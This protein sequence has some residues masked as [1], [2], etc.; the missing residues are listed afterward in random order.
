MTRSIVIVLML[1]CM[2]CFVSDF[3]HC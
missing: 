2:L 1:F 3:C